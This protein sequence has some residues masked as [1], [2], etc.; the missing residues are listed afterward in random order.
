MLVYFYFN[1]SSTPNLTTL[2]VPNQ[3]NQIGV[4]ATNSERIEGNVW[5][6]TYNLPEPYTYYAVNSLLQ[7]FADPNNTAQ[8]NALSATT[9]SMNY[10]QKNLD[11]CKDLRYTFCF[12]PETD[13]N[14]FCPTIPNY[15]STSPTIVCSRVVSS[16]NQFNNANDSSNLVQC[17]QLS[18]PLWT[19]DPSVTASFTQYC[20]KNTTSYDCQCYNRSKVSLYQ[21][22][23]DSL[24]DAAVADTCWY[25][26]CMYQSN[27]YVPPELQ[28]TPKPC[29]SVCANVIVN[30]DVKG[31]V[32]MQDI[33]LVNVCFS[34]ATT[35][36][37]IQNISAQPVSPKP[38]TT[39][40]PSTTTS[41]FLTPKP[42]KNF[43]IFSSFQ[44]FIGI[45]VVVG[46]IFLGCIIYLLKYIRHLKSNLPGE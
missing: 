1:S 9:L 5:K 27:I 21:T 30:A 6:I 17:S 34:D 41:P 11:T 18:V 26:P 42:E 35:V 39:K 19:S 16:N 13:P 28:A 20:N 12:T 7:K 36:D 8:N 15:N 31:G 43:N 38:S 10:Y 32:N 14:L 44:F 37:N 46:F 24:A 23:K 33:S 22:V 40:T 25:K 2:S 4:Q 45:M 29:P 3:G